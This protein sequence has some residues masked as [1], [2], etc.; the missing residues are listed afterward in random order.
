[1]TASTDSQAAGTRRPE[2]ASVPGRSGMRLIDALWTG[3]VLLAVA[4]AVLTGLNWSGFKGSDGIAEVGSSVST[5]AYATLGAMIV[6]RVRNPIGWLLL[7]AGISLGLM[8]LIYGYAALGITLHPGAVPAPQQVGA[9]SE[10][11]FFPVVAA[12]ACVLLLFPTGTL[13]S[14]RW[15][16]AVVLNFLATG[17]L[18][19]GFILIPRRVALPAPG[20]VSLRYQNPFGV[21][22][23]G[24]HLPG[25]PSAIP[26][27]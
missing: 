18:M 21:Q 19:I 10:W 12:L 2:V 25:L 1:M 9:V 11:L 22:R 14:R 27:P 7:T 20:G 5:V 17:L 26:I 16:P 23:S 6:R 24:V 8:V 13:L 4:G 3:S 15:R